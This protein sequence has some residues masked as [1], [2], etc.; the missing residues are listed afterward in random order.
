MR[1]CHSCAS[2][3]FERNE[4]STRSFHINNSAPFSI[5]AESIETSWAPPKQTPYLDVSRWHKQRFGDSLATLWIPLAQYYLQNTPIYL[6]FCFRIAGKC[7]CGNKIT[8]K[9]LAQDL[10]NLIFLQLLNVY[11]RKWIWNITWNNVSG[12][13]G[14]VKQISVSTTGAV[15]F[16]NLPSRNWH[17]SVLHTS[18]QAGRVF[19]NRNFWASLMLRVADV[20]WY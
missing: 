3:F 8:N 11:E 16:K 6:A 1:K 14:L 17:S 10:L 13:S 20:V 2:A 4:L 15:V 18:R 12:D 7:A 9:Q 19:P 5:R